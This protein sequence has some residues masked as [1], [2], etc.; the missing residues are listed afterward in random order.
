MSPFG[1]KIRGRAFQTILQKSVP[2]ICLDEVGF[3]EKTSQI[4]EGRLPPE[5]VSFWL[6]HL[7]RCFSDDIAKIHFPGCVLD[8]AGFFEKKH[9]NFGRSFTPC[10]C[11]HLA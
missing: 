10:G 11:L 1:L 4:S 8:E 2:R 7:W 5:D 6:V 9:S 3:F